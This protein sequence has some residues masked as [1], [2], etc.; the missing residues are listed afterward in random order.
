MTGQ[1]HKSYA[2]LHTASPG[3]P[4]SFG[5]LFAFVFGVIGLW[6]L[7]DGASPRVWSLTVAGAFAAVSLVCPRLLDSLNAL[8]SRF[9]LVLGLVVTPV[10]MAFIFFIGVVPTGLA[11]RLFRK[12]LLKLRFDPDAASYWIPR[13]DSDASSSSMK[14]QF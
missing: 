1:T 3:S 2:E 12:D 6:P 4:R 7:I 10:I 5:F 14:N 13:A 8:W 9:G 11:V